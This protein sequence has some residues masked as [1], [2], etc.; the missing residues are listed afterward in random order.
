MAR[1]GR[2]EWIRTIEEFTAS[3]LT[4]RDFAEQRRLSLPRP[5]SVSPAR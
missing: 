3:G 2:D 5:N 1:L 4:Q